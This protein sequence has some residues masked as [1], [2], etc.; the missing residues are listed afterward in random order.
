MS[1][2]RVKP[3]LLL[4]AVRAA[5]RQ[6]QFL[7]VVSADDAKARFERHLD[8]SPLPAEAVSLAAS[9]GR[10]LSADVAA[11]TDVPPFDRANVDGFAL[12]AA[13]TAGATDATPRRLTLNAEVLACGRAPQI[14]VA[15]HTATAIA[16]GG[17]IPRG[18]DAVLMIEHTELIDGASPAIDLRRA[19]S[20][21]QFVSYAGSDIARGET[22]LRRGA[23]IS[24]REIG[25]LAACGFARIDVVRRP[26]VAVLSTGDE[27]TAPGGPLAPG[28]V[29]DS[30]GAIIAAAVTE[31]GGE[32]IAYGAF[33]DDEAALA[34]AVRRALAECDMVM[35]S[36]GTSKGAG[37]L[38]Y[39]VVSQLG[40]PG[41]IVHGVALKPGKPLCL[42][43][44]QGKP[45]AVLPGFPTSAIFTFHAFVAPVIRAKAGLPPD[46]AVTVEARVPMRLSSELGRKEFVLVALVEGEDGKIAFPIP[47]GSG[48]VTTFSQA[49]G[50][51]E[52]D[53]L[54]SAVDAGTR[55]T[56]TLIGQARAPD[57]VIAGSHC[58]ALDAV[59]SALSE[60]GIT[61]RT[62]AVGS[63]GGVAAA[64]RGECDLAPIHL[65]DPTTGIY[66]EQYAGGGLVLVRGW[67]RMQGIVFR[68]GDARFEVKSAHDAVQ[69]ALADS[70]CIMVNRNA[71]A[72]TRILIDRLVGKARPAGYGNQPRS[73]NAVAAAVAQGRADW[74]V[75]IASVAA[76][77]GLDSCRCRRKTTISS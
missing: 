49:D 14:S 65:M 27:L 64:R 47:K 4:D 53:A 50:F 67:Q 48:S 26:R 19:V 54:A 30:N 39:R 15:P 52:V 51:L 36:G 33:P 62:I 7:E 56:V 69:A 22:L 37:D 6:E 43:V 41:V 3:S 63:M 20:P 17:M 59:L 58:V 10:L 60:Q 31:A 12:R 16:T 42:A 55:A 29:Y 38:S 35:L 73:H 28:A 5:A 77:Y 23:T 75:A 25:M 21:G 44:A 2:A 72:G 71:G 40:A 11:P 76:M 46:A 32:A 66:N 24:S 8:L 68:T 57:L 61:A 45:I 1:D 34:A 13:D 74:G 18:A 9:L 70:G